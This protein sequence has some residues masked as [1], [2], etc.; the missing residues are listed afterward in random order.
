[1]WELCGNYKENK[2]VEIV[3]RRYVVTINI[4]KILK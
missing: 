4:I 1:M 2:N 3:V